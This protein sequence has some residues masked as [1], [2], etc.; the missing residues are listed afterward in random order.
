MEM[1]RQLYEGM[2][3]H[4]RLALPEEACGLIAGQNGRAVRLYPVENRLHS[5]IAYEMEP[6]PQIEAML[7]ME[8]QGWDLLGI[9]HSHPVGPPVPSPTDVAKSYYPDA[10]Y[11]IVSF[12]DPERPVSR[13]FLLRDGLAQEISLS[14]T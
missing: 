10:Q 12:E 7:A 8:T 4:L 9:F 1:P 13:N 3:D 5:P 11:V 6:L 2:I 14:I